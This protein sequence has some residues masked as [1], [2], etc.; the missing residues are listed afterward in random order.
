MFKTLFFPH[1][2]LPND[3]FLRQQFLCGNHL[4]RVHPS[5]RKPRDSKPVKNFIAETGFPED[6]IPAEKIEAVSDRFIWTIERA[7]RANQDQYIRIIGKYDK[8][9]ASTKT[10]HFCRADMW[11]EVVRCLEEFGLGKVDQ[12]GMWCFS[13]RKMVMTWTTCLAL[14]YQRKLQLSRCTDDP[15]YDDL[16]SMIECFP[17]HESVK[18]SVYRVIL[19][20]P[21]ISLKDLGDLK[22]DRLKELRFHLQ[23]E[24]S[25]FHEELN[26][27]KK[28]ESF[29]SFQSIK[30]DLKQINDRLCLIS[31]KI[32]DSLKKEGMKPVWNYGQYRWYVT[33]MHS[34]DATILSNPV[35]IKKMTLRIDSMPVANEMRESVINSEASLI[36]G[37]TS[38]NTNQGLIGR[39]FNVF[40]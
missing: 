23:S 31:R 18:D 29:N 34:P 16:A 37:I 12:A 20:F 38:V 28:V 7:Y 9:R 10:F 32:S 40:R 27:V 5:D 33:E 25:A 36:W 15:E 26:Q 13:T 3:L 11:P 21:Y 8:E 39:I 17:D 6:I 14:E 35:S 2:Y 19:D 4:L 30:E 22:L 24:F 1:F